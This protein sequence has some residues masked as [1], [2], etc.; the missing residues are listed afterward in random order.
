MNYK[1]FA[2]LPLLILMLS[3]FGFAQEND[4]YRNPPR[5]EDHFYR[6]RV[7]LRIDLEEKINLPMI[8]AVPNQIYSETAFTNNNGIIASLLE[9]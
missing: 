8:T 1:R 9:D 5:P 3:P 2:I 7:V 6:K 4:P